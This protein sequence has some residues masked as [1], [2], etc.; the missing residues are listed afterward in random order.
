MRAAF[1]RHTDNI[2]A[3]FIRGRQDGVY[4]MAASRSGNTVNAV[5]GRFMQRRSH[6]TNVTQ[7]TFEIV[8]NRDHANIII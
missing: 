1:I 3:A 2:C 7:R 4:L 8:Q 5:N 6:I